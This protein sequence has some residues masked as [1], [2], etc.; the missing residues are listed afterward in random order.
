MTRNVDDGALLRVLSLGGGLQSSCLVEMTVEGVLPRLDAVVFAD[1][2]G[3]MPA[4][5]AHVDYLRTRLALI[6]VPLLTVS[7]GNLEADVLAAANGTRTHAPSLPTPLRDSTTGKLERINSYHCSFDY[8]RRAVEAAV[9]R[10]C[11]PR[12]TWHISTVHQWIGY[13][14]DEGSRV[15]QSDGCRCGHKLA[16]H[17]GRERTC[18]T[19]VA[20]EDGLPCKRSCIKFDPWQINVYPLIELG[21]RRG[22]AAIWLK[23]HNLPE[24]SRSACW[25]C[26]NRGNGHWR[27][28][29]QNNPDLWARAV[30]L[31]EAIRKPSHALTG[32]RYL[33]QSGTPLVV[34][35]I[36][37]V[38]QRRSEDDGQD[39]LFDDEGAS[40]YDCDA[41]VCFT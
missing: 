41:G 15:K 7:N 34:A 40:P 33:H 14:T 8:K 13:S 9:K 38:A 22:D 10:L 18:M 31:D 26:P 36:R 17:H 32:E 16:A 1:T 27:T 21:M 23:T 4:T 11:G 29:Q 12:G 39:G 5:Y 24:P 19:R 30:V 2:G 25:F 3:E 28:L 20:K 6:D 37:S 35:D